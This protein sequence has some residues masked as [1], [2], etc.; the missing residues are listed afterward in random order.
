MLCYM[1][2][3]KRELEILSK[4]LDCKRE[5]IQMHFG[6]ETPTFFSAEQ[7]KIIID[8]IKSYF[9]NFVA[10]AEISCEIDPVI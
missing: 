7:L 8:G 2:Y 10:S 3:L 4:H 5:V 6:G 1:E 9:P